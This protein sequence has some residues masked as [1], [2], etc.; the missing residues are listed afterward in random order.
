MPYCDSCGKQHADKENFC[1][2]C[3][4]KIVN[5]STSA[6][7]IQYNEIKPKKYKFDIDI[8]L[9]RELLIKLLLKKYI[10]EYLYIFIV[11]SL[12]C[13]VSYT[14]Y[15]STNSETASGWMTYSGLFAGISLPALLFRLKKR[16]D[17]IKSLS[18]SNS[19][20]NIWA[21][22]ETY[23]GT[24]GNETKDFVLHAYNK[25]FKVPE[26]ILPMSIEEC[27]NMINSKLD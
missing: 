12:V 22:I 26:I 10:K 5:N 24:S 9:K 16:R 7:V 2:S 20:K 4:A 18:L 14:Y 1:S 11:S 17:L 8:E 23:K 25:T 19:I 27:L 6:N 3:G 15:L 21:E 13:V